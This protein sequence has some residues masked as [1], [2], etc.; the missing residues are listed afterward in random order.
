MPNSVERLPEVH[1]DMVKTLL[2]LQVFL[3]EYSKIENLFSC[4]PS[5]SEACLFLFG[6]IVAP[7]VDPKTK[8]VQY[9]TVIS[10]KFP[11]GRNFI[12]PPLDPNIKEV[13]CKT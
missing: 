13:R 11:K 4:D 9:N 2:A 1:E 12:I 10:S 3:T 8:E 5:Y 6:E 7:P